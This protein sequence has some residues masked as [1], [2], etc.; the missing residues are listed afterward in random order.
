MDTLTYARPLVRF[1]RSPLPQLATVQ[2]TL[3]DVIEAIATE[4]KSDEE[5]LVTTIVAEL[6][7]SRRARFIAKRTTAAAFPGPGSRQ[8]AVMSASG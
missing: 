2:T 5:A 3:Y 1:V 4:V 8:T 7:H 6:L